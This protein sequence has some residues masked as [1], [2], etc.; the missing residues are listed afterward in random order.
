MVDF[1]ELP[2]DGVRFEQLIREI[3]QRS[4]FEV[5]WT[6]VGPDGGRDLIAIERATGGLA[7][8]ERRWLVSCKHFANASR[9]VGLGDI[10]D[11]PGHCAAAGAT[12]F[13]LACST[14]PSSAVVSRLEETE[15]N[16]KI[17]CRYWDG[18]E[19]EKRLD[20]ASTFPLRLL[21]FPKSSA[22]LP[23]R[24]Y[25]TT[26][27]SFWAANYKDY[28]MYLS[29]RTSHLFPKLA[30]VEEIVR[31]IESI[32]LPADEDDWNGHYLRPRAIY[33]DDK[34]E[35]YLVFIDYIHPKRSREKLSRRSINFILQDGE[36]LY[37]EGSTTWYLTHWDVKYISENQASE[38]FQVDH[39]SYYEPYMRSFEHG[40]PREEGILSD[41]LELDDM[42]IISLDN[43][44]GE[45]G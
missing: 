27:P 22:G 19:I 26:H 18:I 10:Q 15:K 25:N 3:L 2:E 32:P 36:G 8:F 12:G 34:H 17:V 29:C 14:Q 4:G 7:P 24:I 38:R 40:T 20:T 41:Q 23:W 21:F 33:Y 16:T 39:K 5:H 43:D 31:K 44:D 37:S 11:I 30:D 13:L 45:E 1:T 42:E 28:F 9:S 35:Q 6:G